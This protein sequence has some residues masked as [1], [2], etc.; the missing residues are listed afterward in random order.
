M[1]VT[2]GLPLLVRLPHTADSIGF[3]TT[4]EAPM[5]N[6]R[7]L[8]QWLRKHD[9][10]E[11]AMPVKLDMQVSTLDELRQRIVRDDVPPS[12]RRY[13]V[14]L[15]DALKVDNPAVSNRTDAP[16]NNPAVRGSLKRALEAAEPAN[17]EASLRALED[18]MYAQSNTASRDSLWHTWCVL[19]N[20]WDLPPVPIT[21]ALAKGMASSF[22]AGTYRSARNYFN[23]AKEEHV[24]LTSCAVPPDVERTIANCIRSTERGIGPSQLKDSFM[25]ELLRSSVRS[26]S[27]HLAD[28]FFMNNV[29]AQV[30]MVII[31]C[32]WMT[33]GI[34]LGTAKA[35]HVWTEE[36]TMSAFWTLPVHKTDT[37]GSCVTR[38]HKC[39]CARGNDPLCPFHAA[40]RHLARIKS[41]FP[42]TAHDYADLAL[43]PDRNGGHFQKDSIIKMI[44]KVISLTKTALQRPGPRGS[45]MDKFG[46]HVLRVSGAQ[47][48]AR[49]G[50]Q[51]YIIQLIGRWGSMAVA[52]YVQE[53]F[54]LGN[55]NVAQDTVDG[56]EQQA[57]LALTHEPKV[58]MDEEAIKELI[59]KMVKTAIAEQRKYIGNPETKKVHLPAMPENMVQS[60][61]WHTSCWWPYGLRNH[62]GMSEIPH[63]WTACTKCYK[64]KA[65]Y[66]QIDGEEDE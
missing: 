44:R 5:S 13:I 30:D 10:G 58:S 1:S 45:P 33:R 64:A 31:G 9:L 6:F 16:T 62:V 56:L 54:I 36:S 21:I 22:K 49:A 43:F 55:V 39:C 28:R 60:V 50:I 15:R 14:V 18:D 11:V 20:A 41:A 32:W 57:P 52:R 35:I 23:R 65:M 42:A 17:R 2:C 25:V 53:A 3:S 40:K 61:Y 24:M 37:T 8:I 46:E 4:R 7:E 12:V 59:D 19:A 48:M 29:E 38:P 66:N 26:D 51:L 34:E 47:L 63:G 27:V